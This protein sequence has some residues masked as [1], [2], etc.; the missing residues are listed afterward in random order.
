MVEYFFYI[1]PELQTKLGASA[2]S[3]V[4]WPANL[5]IPLTYK[6]YNTR[7]RETDTLAYANFA[8]C[9]QFSIRSR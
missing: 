4:W 9:S 1:Y 2:A 6:I 5:L 3:D 7:N 8:K